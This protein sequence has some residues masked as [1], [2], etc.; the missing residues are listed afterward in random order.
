MTDII[1]VPGDVIIRVLGNIEKNLKEAEFPRLTEE[2]I[3]DDGE[4]YMALRC[5]RCGGSISEGGELFAHGV[6]W[7]QEENEPLGEWDF[8]HGTV[9][10]GQPDRPDTETLYYTHGDS[11]GH[12]VSLPE[13][14]TENWT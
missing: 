12:A 13:G 2:E 4:T 1:P 8:D 5:P 3:T 10:F 9:S 6:G 11:P 14:W 7:T